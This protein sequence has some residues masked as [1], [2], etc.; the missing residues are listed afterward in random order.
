ME[1]FAMKVGATC[2]PGVQRSAKRYG[3]RC[4]FPFSQCTPPVSTAI[5]RNISTSGGVCE[6]LSAHWILH[7]ANNDSLWNWLYTNGQVNLSRLN[8]QVMELQSRGILSDDQDALTENWLRE[9]GLL[10]RHNSFVLNPTRQLGSFRM[11]FQGGA[12]PKKQDGRTGVLDRNALVRA[13][14]YDDTAGAGQYK[15]LGLQG[16]AGAHAMALWVAQ[17][18]AFFDPNFGEFWFENPSD[19]SRWFT[20]SFWYRSLYAFGLSGNFELFPYAKSVN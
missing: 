11:Q 8:A 4:T 3:G 6:S 1:W 13:I 12:Q 16:N 7:H 10:R 19:F 2:A 14:L 20:Q 9:N 15:K 18:V 17:D 5:A